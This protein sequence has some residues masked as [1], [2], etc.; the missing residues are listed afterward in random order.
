M[1]IRNSKS[2]KAY[3]D[4]IVWIFVTCQLW[5]SRYRIAGRINRAFVILQIQ[6]ESDLKS[7]SINENVHDISRK[8][9]REIGKFVDESWVKSNDGSCGNR[10]ECIKKVGCKQYMRVHWFRMCKKIR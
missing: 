2:Y 6:A 4:I 5:A 9:T 8:E 7:N 3:Y 10:L 1:K